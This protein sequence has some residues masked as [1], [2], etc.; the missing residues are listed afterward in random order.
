MNTAISKKVESSFG[1]EWSK[2]H[3]I[4][5]QFEQNFLSY[6]APVTPPYFRD[7][8][9]LDAGC[10]NGRHTYYAAKYGAKMVVGIDISEKAVK[11][12]EQ[13]LKE[14]PNTCFRQ[15]SIEE[16]P[17]VVRF[18]YIMVIGVLH[19]L[20]NPQAAFSKLVSVL[21]DG[22]C[23]SA[24]VYGKGNNRLAIWL[25][26]PIRKL[27]AKMPHSV[28]YWLCLFPAAVVQL[29]NWLRLPIFQQYR[30]FPFGVK[31]NDS[32]DVFATPLVR[33]YT[34][35]DVHGWFKSEG[36]RDIIVGIRMLNG[37]EKGIRGFGIK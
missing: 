29:C 6:I 34:I 20:E 36:L 3:S 30:I 15:L 1:Y 31:C 33:Y 24:W 13:N 28:L 23:I 7:K 16:M 18:D 25:F 35:D 11:V 12:A 2:F 32:F 37:V 27:T 26:D 19:H 21:K 4:Y 17:R 14:F 9:V 10:G 8:V 22:G 5:D